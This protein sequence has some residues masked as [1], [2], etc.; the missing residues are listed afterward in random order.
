[1]QT[2]S[3]SLAP[4]LLRAFLAAAL[5]APAFGLAACGVGTGDS[6]GFGEG[7]G[8]MPSTGTS[9]LEI[10]TTSVPAASRDVGYPSTPLAVAGAEQAVTWS[11]AEGELP[12][13]MTLTSDG[14]LAGTPVSAGYFEFTVRATDGFDADTQ[15]LA[16]AVDRF[17]I[18][19]V[20]GV[21]FG[22][23]WSGRAVELAC[24]GFSGPVE[25]EVISNRSGG[26]MM[27]AVGARGDAVYLPG[28]VHGAGELDII[29]A[30]DT[31][32]G[33]LAEIELPV[34]ADP[35]AMHIA[36]FGNTDVWY[37]DFE[38]RHG[39]HPFASDFHGGLAR[40]GLRAPT[41]SDRLGTEAD[42]LADLL[43][44][45]RVLRHIN[46]MYLRNP[47]GT[48][49]AAGLAISFPLE[50]P[51]VGYALPPPGGYAPGAANQFSVMAI[52]DGTHPAIVGTAYTDFAGN[53]LQEHNAPGGPLGSLGT[54]VN[55]IIPMVRFMSEQYGSALEDEPVSAADVPA[56]KALLHGLPS[57]GGRYD[58]ID[59]KSNALSR[60]LAYI[61]AHE[62]GHSLGL[63]HAHHYEPGSIMASGA[64]FSP[65]VEYHFLAGE[66]DALRA[67]LPGEGRFT[68]AL[69]AGPAGAPGPV[70]AATLPGGGVHVCGGA[71]HD[72]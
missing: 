49:G 45:V 41:S 16:L 68:G 23:A 43:V 60:G 29:R 71:C 2:P 46:R 51:G 34:R 27:S 10:L 11:V 14:R 4:R 22:E 13:G 24:S 42:R 40:M 36:R 59:Y 18:T 9:N 31:G 50:R 72:R 35:T 30:T 55:R 66:L 65:A 63:P 69:K 38:G 56:L 15:R 8:S 17:G 44:R 47:D 39:A 70:A 25:I 32:T 5:L 1:M 57:P 20:G 6:T 61:A 52:C 28:Q 12:G 67:S 3:P 21:E 58:L 53:G 48:G 62:I 33:A 37:L 64:T 7:A 19:A 26:T 54:F